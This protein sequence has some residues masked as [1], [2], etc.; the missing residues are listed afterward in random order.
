MSDR[1]SLPEPAVATIWA[2]PAALGESPLWSPEDALLYWVDLRAGHLHRC[3][4]DGADH[5]CFA[6]DEPLGAI[7]MAQRGR[8]IL[9]LASRVIVF[10][11]ASGAQELVHR[12]SDPPG[13]RC[14]DGRCDAGGNFWCGRMPDP[15]DPTQL[16]YIV[17]IAPGGE[18]TRMIAQAITPNGIAFSPGGRL[19]YWSDSHPSVRRIWRARYDPVGGAIGER[20]L[21]ADTH[22]MPGRP[23]GAAVDVLGRYWSAAADGGEVVCFA[24]D[25]S[26]A[27]RIALPVSKPTMPAFGG[28]DRRTMFVT[29]ALPG[30]AAVHSTHDGAVFA[31]PVD[32]AGIAEHRFGE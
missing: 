15:P 11:P 16:G 10:D 19:A 27:Q 14:N 31:I 18:V 13:W 7:G 28:A 21:F 1:D 23:D 3:A 5:A 2:G 32:A 20:Q 4:A 26:I 12:W 29:S 8:L 17:R 9:G 30:G 22:G 25:G 24:T 6:F